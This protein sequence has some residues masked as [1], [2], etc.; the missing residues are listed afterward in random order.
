MLDPAAY[1]ATTS[2]GKLGGNTPLYSNLKVIAVPVLAIILHTASLR[3][4]KRGLISNVNVQFVIVMGFSI[5][6]PCK[7]RRKMTFCTVIRLKGNL[8]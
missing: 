6:F 8:V 7:V 3:L 1:L 4:K 2:Q 5:I